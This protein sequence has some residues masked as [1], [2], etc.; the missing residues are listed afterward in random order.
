MLISIIAVNWN[1]EKILE[2]FI[3]NL[4]SINYADKEI[5]IV[6]NGSCD[7]SVE[8]LKKYKQI[9]YYVL[10]KNLG[11]AGGNNF[12]IRQSSGDYLM[13]VNTDVICPPDIL[14]GFS[15]YYNKLPESVAEKKGAFMPVILLADGK[16][17]S[18]GSYLYKDFHPYNIGFNEEHTKIDEFLKLRKPTGFY[19]ACVFINKKMIEDIGF[20]NEEYF[21][22]HEETDLA[23]RGLC[24]GWQYDIIRNIQIEHLHSYSSVELSF[25]KIF[26][27]ERNRLFN[28]IKY[29][30]LSEILTSPYYTLTRYFKTLFNKKLLHSKK[31][32]TSV[33]SKFVIPAAIMSAYAALIFYIDSLFY[34]RYK[35]KIKNRDFLVTFKNVI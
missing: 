13:L 25:K 28:L 3:E 27:S 30:L 21:L 31:T 33:F 12:G 18:L 22:Y 19:G 24:K 4:I 34:F 26:Y 11:F 29:G 9:K 6:D 14:I 2:K 8:I 7:N 35:N 15:E 16:I 23:I 17:N 5:I 10:K 1:G 32:Q 20:F